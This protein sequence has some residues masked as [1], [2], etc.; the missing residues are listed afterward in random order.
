MYICSILHKSPPATALYVYIVYNTIV[1]NTSV[2]LKRVRWLLKMY[3]V[4]FLFSGLRF[5]TNDGAFIFFALTFWKKWLHFLIIKYS[6]LCYIRCRNFNISRT[7]EIERL[8]GLDGFSIYSYQWIWSK[9]FFCAFFRTFVILNVC[10]SPT[11]LLQ[12]KITGL[13]RRP[14]PWP[15]EVY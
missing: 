2:F 15:W 5:E 13:F 11:Y 3:D 8:N 9:I 14:R 4:A 7:Y 10:C 12:G 6:E 1:K